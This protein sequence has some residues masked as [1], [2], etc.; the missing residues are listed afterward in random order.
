[1]NKNTSVQTQMHIAITNATEFL[2]FAILEEGSALLSE[3]SVHEKVLLQSQQHRQG[4]TEILPQHSCSFNSHVCA[5][6]TLHD[7][8]INI[9]KFIRNG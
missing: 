9:G 7:D 2:R 6:V 4:E 3:G 8:G 5:R 1:M